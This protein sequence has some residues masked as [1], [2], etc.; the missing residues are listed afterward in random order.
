MGFV[1][2]YHVGAT[3]KITRYG[4]NDDYVELKVYEVSGTKRN[5]KAR[6][7]V[8]GVSDISDLCLSENEGDVTLRDH[9]RVGLV[10]KPIVSRNSV[11]IFCQAPYNYRIEYNFHNLP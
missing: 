5:R 2:Q 3:I 10:K 11:P 1:R 4:N 9:I 6:L 7:H 8:K